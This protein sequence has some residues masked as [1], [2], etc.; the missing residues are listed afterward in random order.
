MRAFIQR[1]KHASVCVDEKEC[2]K[3]NNG[4]LILL[5]VGK[6]DSEAD[7]SLLAN[8]VL[9]LRIFHDDQGKMNRSLLD[10]DGEALIVSQFTLYADYSHGNRPNFLP[11]AD[12]ATANRLYTQ[13]CKYMEERL[14]YVGMGIFGAEMQVYLQ[15]D[16]PVSMC[17]DTDIL[18]TKGKME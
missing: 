7:V 9:K 6:D 10:I 13:F 3:C 18:K 17:I 16:G 14:R 12:P 8:K 15:N 5:G 11:A 2:G 1:V 4:L